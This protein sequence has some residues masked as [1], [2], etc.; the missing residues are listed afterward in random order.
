MEW[1]LKEPRR[2]KGLAERVRSRSVDFVIVLRAFIGHAEQETVLD[3]CR[4]ADVPFV[5]VDSGYGVNQVKLAI[6]RF[7][8][9]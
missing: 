4:A 8:N 7:C 5:I 1:E 9:L 6:E 3:A 2:L